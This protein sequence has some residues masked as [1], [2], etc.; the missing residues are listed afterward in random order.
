MNLRLLKNPESMDK[1]TLVDQ[2]LINQI[3]FCST[4]LPTSAPQVKSTLDKFADRIENLGTREL[5]IKEFYEATWHYKGLRDLIVPGLSDKEWR[6]SVGL[7]N[8]V[9]QEAINSRKKGLISTLFSSFDLRKFLGLPA[10]EYKEPNP[11]AEAEVYIAYGRKRQAIEVLE[12]ALAENPGR[13]D[14][15]EKLDGLRRLK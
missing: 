2:K 13:Q 5:A 1:E 12:R 3:R 8:E 10:A 9:A 14:V 6:K 11:L 4:E 7:L 15:Q